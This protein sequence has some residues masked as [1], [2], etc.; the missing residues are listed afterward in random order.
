MMAMKTMPT[1]DDLALMP[2]EHRH[3]VIGGLLSPVMDGEAHES[4]TIVSC[5]LLDAALGWWHGSSSDLCVRCIEHHKASHTAPAL[6]TYGG[7][8][9]TSREFTDLVLRQL[10]SG[11]AD[12]ILKQVIGKD[13]DDLIRRAKEFGAS[14]DHI[15]E[16]IKASVLKKGFSPQVA[17]EL[18]D[19]HKLFEDSPPEIVP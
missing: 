3:K 7:T 8:D 12:A 11:V 9:P 17:L 1:P 15:L 4:V 5:A 2:C 13:R 6:P 19:R 10:S 16:L 18:A 14:H